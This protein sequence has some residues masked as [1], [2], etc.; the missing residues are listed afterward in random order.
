[1]SDTKEYIPEEL[2]EDQQYL[3]DTLNGEMTVTDSRQIS[4]GGYIKAIDKFVEYKIDK[5]L[6][7]KKK[8][9]KGS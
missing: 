6:N 1:M 4:V 7:G 5:A 9:I 8:T 3:L 2:T